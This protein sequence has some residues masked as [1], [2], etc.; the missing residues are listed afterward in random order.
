MTGMQV[1]RQLLVS[2]YYYI[3]KTQYLPGIQAGI[4]GLLSFN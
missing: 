4:K 2:I 1:H 3:S